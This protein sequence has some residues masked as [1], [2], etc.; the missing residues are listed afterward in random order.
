MWE[1]PFGL[2]AVEA[3][4]AGRPVCASRV[5]GLQEIV[6]HDET[7]FLFDRGDG[8]GLTKVLARLLDHPALRARC[9]AV[10]RQL[11]EREYDWHRVI[12]R[13]YVPLIEE[14]CS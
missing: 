7:G 1:E 13:H 6:R 14:L 12:T 5:G 2:V 9:G 8:A 11:V 3:M 4:A 10:G